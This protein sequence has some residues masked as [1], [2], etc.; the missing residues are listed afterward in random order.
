MWRGVSVDVDAAE[1]A[2]EEYEENGTRNLTFS[3]ARVS[4]ATLCTM[5][6]FAEAWVALGPWPTEVAEDE[7]VTDV[8]EKVEAGV[9]RETFRPVPPQTKDGPGW[10]THPDPTEDITNYWVDGR[11]ALKIRWGQGGDFNRCRTQLAKYVQNPDWLAGLCANLHYRAL[12]I[13]PGEHRAAGKVEPMQA[14]ENVEMA[15]VTLV[16]S[17][18]VKERISADFFKNPMLEEKTPLIVD[19]ETGHVYGHVATWDTCHI[20]KVPCVTPP[21]SAM[22]YGFF[23]HGE[24]LTDAGPV[25]VGQITLGTGHASAELGIIGA[26]AHYD[27]TGSAVADVYCGEDDLGIWVSGRLRDGVTEKQIH[28]LRAAAPSGDWRGVMVAGSESLEMCGILAVNVPGFPIPRTRVSMSGERQISLVAAGIVE[29]ANPIDPNRAARVAA[30]KAT[31]RSYRVEKL[32][33][34]VRA[35][36]EGK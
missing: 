25:P 26:M 1:L 3:K 29:P 19:D 11:G 15:S 16:A 35:A 28:E 21:H 22:D 10:I 5:P 34:K 30:L 23:L 33:A 13:W 9:S 32:K 24:V 14:D 31:G 7:K 6:A 4:A 2:V 20:G 8:R 17:A 36:K 27:N 12:G 18:G